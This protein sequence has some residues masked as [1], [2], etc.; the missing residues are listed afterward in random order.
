MSRTPAATRA[1][2]P[3]GIPAGLKLLLVLALATVGCIGIYQVRSIVGPVFFALTL[4]LT[5]RPIHRFLVARHVPGFLAAF[6]SVLTLVITLLLVLAV[7][8]WSL[9]E[10]PDV[11]MSYSSEFNAL[12]Q[13]GSEYLA[14][15]GMPV[16]K[17]L[18]NGIKQLNIGSTLSQVLQAADTVM[19]VMSF[20]VV[21]TTAM[22]FIVVDTITLRSRAAVTLAHDSQLYKALSS[23]ERGVRQYW[24]VST[25]FGA[26]VAVV[27]GIVLYMLDVPLPV[28]WALFSFITNYI[29][30]VGFVI[31]VIPPAVLGA[32]SGDP[33][34]ALWVVI[35]YSVI[36]GTIQGIFQPKFTGEAVGLSTTVTF[37]SLLFWTVVIGPMGAILAVPLTLMAKALLVDSS[38]DT[39]WINAFLMPEP[40]VSAAVK[41]G[42]LE[43]QFSEDMP[44]DEIADVATQ[45]REL[46][47][48]LSLLRS[49]GGAEREGFAKETS[50]AKNVTLSENTAASNE[51]MGER[52]VGE[53]N[54][55]THEHSHGILDKGGH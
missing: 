21:V 39:L 34:T 9:A 44:D 13:Q 17:L 29:P 33:W 53:P 45:V 12:V 36:N 25:V 7:T 47:A 11:V 10:L 35:A 52:E 19:G 51:S 20:L 26:I 49:H 18:E 28:A 54:E 50:H 31:G 6:A 37:M 5:V 14:S 15:L 16:D 24:L 38:R 3:V 32:L 48:K 30:N 55:E 22:L 43:A 1:A 42:E 46:S 23:F 27:N 4:V 8:T 41:S 40:E 2:N